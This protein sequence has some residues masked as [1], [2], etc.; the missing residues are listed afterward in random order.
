LARWL[1]LY[2]HGLTLPVWEM[3]S[4]NL[5][6]DML[7]DVT[8]GAN[9]GLTRVMGQ[10]AYHLSFTEPEQDWEIWI[11]ADDEK[12]LPLM[13]AGRYNDEAKT[14]YQALFH[15]WSFKPRRKRS[16]FKLKRKPTERKIPFATLKA[17]QS[18][19]GD[20]ETDAMSSSDDK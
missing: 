16:T 8:G 15:K 4:T 20:F 12:P 7:G 11:S 19:G 9:L 1:F 10:W 18:P 17:A 13:M 3:M 14:Q 6:D 2:D 5:S